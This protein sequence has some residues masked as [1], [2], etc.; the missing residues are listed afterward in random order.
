MGQPKRDDSA[1]SRSVRAPTRNRTYTSRLSEDPEV[2]VSFLV[3]ARNHSVGRVVTARA[4]N[5]ANSAFV[6]IPF[7]SLRQRCAPSRGRPW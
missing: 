1:P 6:V 5:S 7:S 3:F 2:S 4:V